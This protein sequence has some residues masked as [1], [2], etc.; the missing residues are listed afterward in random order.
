MAVETAHR[1]NFHHVTYNQR[2]QLR[3]FDRML[4]PNVNARWHS[5]PARIG[6]RLTA[7]QQ[8]MTARPSAAA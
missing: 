4:R 5:A 7:H 1:G 3:S 6:Q 2:P 8:A